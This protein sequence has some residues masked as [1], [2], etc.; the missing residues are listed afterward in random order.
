VPEP[1]TMVSAASALVALGLFVR[2]KRDA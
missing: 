1:A 2:R